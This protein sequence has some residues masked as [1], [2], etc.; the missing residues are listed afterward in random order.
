MHYAVP[1]VDRA[2]SAIS[3]PMLR[4][5]RLA[6]KLGKLGFASPATQ[7]AEP[8]CDAGAAPAIDR[9]ISE[10][11]KR[12]CAKRALPNVVRAFHFSMMIRLRN[13]WPQSERNSSLRFAT[14]V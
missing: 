2:I 8:E 7:F 9:A 4:R 6:L 3:S 14:P 12:R 1:R 10:I 5:P 11:G 13:V